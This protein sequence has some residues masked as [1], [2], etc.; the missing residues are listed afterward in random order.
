MNQQS[1]LG[2]PFTFKV[3]PAAPQDLTVA[4]TMTDRFKDCTLIGDKAYMSKNFSDEL[5]KNNVKLVHPI[6]LS[7]NKK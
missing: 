4:R 5:L 1:S 6:K 2:K 3:T 7:K